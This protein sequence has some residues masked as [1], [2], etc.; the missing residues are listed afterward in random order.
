MQI[1]SPV[2]ML[3]TEYFL[4]IEEIFVFGPKISKKNPTNENII[5]MKHSKIMIRI[6]LVVVFVIHWYSKIK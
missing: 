2:Q 6:K 4:K 3:G 5:A 1:L